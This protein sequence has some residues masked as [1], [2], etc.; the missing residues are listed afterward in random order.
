MPDDMPDAIVPTESAARP[1][2]LQIVDDIRQRIAEGELTE[3]A[4][5]PSERSV[6]DQ[7]GV[8]RMTARRALE[9]LESEGL[10]YS[11]D[12]R[13]RFVSPARLRYN[14]SEMVS[15]VADA[16]SKGS[17]LAIEVIEVR[18]TGADARLAGLLER[19]VGTMVHEYTRLFHSG[20]HAIFIETECVIADLF[21]G[22]LDHDLRQSTTRLLESRYDT[23]SKTG[24][25]IIRMRGVS[26]AE[27]AL[28]NIT[29]HHAAIELE[30]VI[31]DQTGTPFCFGRQVWRGER[32]EFSARAIVSQGTQA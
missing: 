2:F 18:T 30:Q 26:D 7:F 20:G 28:L 15:F 23:L 10:V 22:F 32:A 4:A 8:S 5:I 21:P 29:S 27:A 31:R 24:D 9:A 25:I 17:D 1:R 13:G 6:A 12:R 3:H 11:E 19:P 14:V 16:Q